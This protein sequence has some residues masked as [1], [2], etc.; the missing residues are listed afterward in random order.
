MGCFIGGEL[1]LLTIVNLDIKLFNAFLKSINSLS[2]IKTDEFLAIK[3][4]H[5]SKNL[6]ISLECFLWLFLSASGS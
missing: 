2:F 5:S 3:A 6:L 4:F 1:L